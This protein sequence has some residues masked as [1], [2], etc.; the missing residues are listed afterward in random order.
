VAAAV[1]GSA[2]SSCHETLWNRKQVE[3][4]RKFAEVVDAEGIRLGSDLS[5]RVPILLDH[6]RIPC[7]AG[8]TPAAQD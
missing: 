1:E 3:A 5:V 7:A 2:V 6:Y 8:G 4:C